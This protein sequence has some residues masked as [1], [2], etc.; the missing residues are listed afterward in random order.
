MNPKSERS[1]LG[2]LY[3]QKV[4][5]VDRCLQ[6]KSDSPILKYQN[7]DKSKYIFKDGKSAYLSLRLL[8]TN[9]TSSLR[10]QQFTHQQIKQLLLHT[11]NLQSLF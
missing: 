6:L 4:H 11:E 1:V 10:K 5:Q 3:K 8:D 9:Q 2:L 7:K